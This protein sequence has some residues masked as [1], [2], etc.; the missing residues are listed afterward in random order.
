M[1]ICIE[2]SETLSTNKDFFC[3][4]YT[5]KSG[6]RDSGTFSTN[7]Q[8]SASSDECTHATPPPLPPRNRSSSYLD[9]MLLDSKLPRRLSDSFSCPSSPNL[10]GN[11]ND[12]DERDL[13]LLMLCK[14]CQDERAGKKERRKTQRMTKHAS[15]DK[16]DTI[17][18]FRPN[19]ETN[20]PSSS[21]QDRIS[22]E[23]GSSEDSLPTPFR[24]S[25]P[26]ETDGIYQ[27]MD[28]AWL[29][30]F[31]IIKKKER[32][33]DRRVPDS[34]NYSNT[35]DDVYVEMNLFTPTSAN[36]SENEREKDGK[37]NFTEPPTS[38]NNSE[39]KRQ[40]DGKTDSLRNK[41]R[42]AKKQ[43]WQV[44]LTSCDDVLSTGKEAT[45]HENETNI[46]TSLDDSHSNKN[47]ATA[48]ANEATML[49]SCDN[50]CST[51]SKE[52]EATSM[53]NEAITGKEAI[54]TE[55]TIEGNLRVSGDLMNRRIVFEFEL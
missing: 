35:D 5:P 49:T 15:L 21:D 26:T 34:S 22:H 29:R 50:V 19:M 38:A 12:V 20:E 14:V 39:N 52:S 51:E 28:Q 3:L 24:D 54:A 2:Q 36:N 44:S 40:T 6:R 41:G 8:N 13:E 53:Q 27:E 30:R 46:L 18:V 10:R 37:T 45:P 16:S 11:R 55:T 43:N 23:S 33:S 9:E 48:Q 1:I 47:Q 4:G 7:T 32:E 31:S 42:K 17:V 25:L